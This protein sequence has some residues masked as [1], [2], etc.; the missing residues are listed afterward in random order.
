MLD[1]LTTSCQHRAVSQEDVEERM[2][3][4]QRTAD[5]L[6]IKAHEI[7]RTSDKHHTRKQKLS[8]D[9]LGCFILLSCE[10]A[11]PALSSIELIEG[12]VDKLQPRGDTGLGT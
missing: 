8:E 4:L 5:L 11:R 10:G 6:L 12:Q 2:W 1:S 9:K 7:Y 3:R